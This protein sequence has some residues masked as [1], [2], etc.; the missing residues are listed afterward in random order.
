MLSN[1]ELAFELQNVIVQLRKVIIS[2]HGSSTLK[3][4]EKCTLFLIDELK[5]G[6]PV[7]ISEIANKIKVTLAAV[8]HQ[9]N[10]LEKRGLIRRMPNSGDRRIVRV[11]LTK[12]GRVQVVKLK[13]EF[14]KKTKILTE[15]LG[16]EDTKNLIRLFKKMSE[17]RE[18]IK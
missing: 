4:A 1:N 17:F 18:F 9:I 13:K 15:F 16:E 5:A 14:S 3:G 10:A 7:T 12:S 2:R 11:S 8:T 6:S